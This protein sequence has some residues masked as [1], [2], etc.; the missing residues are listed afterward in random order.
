MVRKGHKCRIPNPDGNQIAFRVLAKVKANSKTAKLG[1]PK[2]GWDN[3]KTENWLN[4]FQKKILAKNWDFPQ[5]IV[6]SPPLA[7]KLPAPRPR[8][9]A[10]N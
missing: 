1:K 7:P 2:L 8:N 3:F 9:F 10:L 6:R 4:R 5:K